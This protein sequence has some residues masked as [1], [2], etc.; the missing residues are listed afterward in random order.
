MKNTTQNTVA[1][2]ITLKQY[3]MDGLSI[4]FNK[5]EEAKPLAVKRDNEKKPKEWN[6]LLQLDS[7]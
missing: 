5:S 6:Y 7:L 4:I 2:K 3:V 1:N